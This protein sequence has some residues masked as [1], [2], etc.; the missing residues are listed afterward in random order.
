VRDDVHT[1][2]SSDDNLSPNQRVK[3]TGVEDV[4]DKTIWVYFGTMIVVVMVR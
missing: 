4:G 3:S 1:L 2:G